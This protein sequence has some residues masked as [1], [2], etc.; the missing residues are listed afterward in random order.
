MRTIEGF[1]IVASERNVGR[2]TPTRNQDVM[3]GAVDLFDK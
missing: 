2:Q 1:G 3:L